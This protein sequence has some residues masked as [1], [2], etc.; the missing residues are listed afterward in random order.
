MSPGAQSNGRD[1]P[2][3]VDDPVPG[4]AAMI[5]DGLV[6][7]KDAV[8]EPVLAQELPE[9]FD[10]VEFGRACWQGQQG[11]VGREHELLGRVPAGLI[12]QQHGVRARR[13]RFGDLGQMQVHRLGG[14]AGMTSPAPVPRA[15]QIAPKR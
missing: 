5:E 15:G 6:G 12:E 2:G 3:L 4:V 14:T 10:W 13:D 11:D 1:T 9:V 8:A 7:G